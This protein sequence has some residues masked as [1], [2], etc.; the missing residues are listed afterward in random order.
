M[1]ELETAEEWSCRL[2]QDLQQT[3]SLRREATAQLEVA[4][5]ASRTQIKDLSVQLRLC[6]NTAQSLEEQLV[7][8]DAQN[9]DLEHQLA[10]LLSAFRSAVGVNHGRLSC[11]S[12]S[13]SRSTGKSLMLPS[14]ILFAL[15]KY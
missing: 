12:A 7:L 11:K 5:E 15:K 8:S 1:R 10:E 4:L 14:T 13:R 2:R 6:E 9:K 3:L